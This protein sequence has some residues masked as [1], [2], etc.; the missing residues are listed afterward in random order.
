MA[1][2]AL[3]SDGW[4]FAGAVVNLAAD[5]SEAAGLLRNLIYFGLGSACDGNSETEVD[6]D[7]ISICDLNR[8][9]AQRE[10]LG[11]LRLHPR[12]TRGGDRSWDGGGISL[13][14]QLPAQGIVVPAS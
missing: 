2:E 10:G 11:L 1:G 6:K 3:C 14:V 4:H 8:K 13:A 5:G 9:L 7:S 12:H